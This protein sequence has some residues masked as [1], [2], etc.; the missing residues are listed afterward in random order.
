MKKKP[1]KRKRKIAVRR[2]IDDLEGMEIEEVSETEFSKNKRKLLKYIT[3]RIQNFER[4][5]YPNL[6]VLTSL[7]YIRKTIFQLSKEGQLFEFAT[8]LSSLKKEIQN[9]ETI[10]SSVI[11][12]ISK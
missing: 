9:L 1:L 6:F 8:K 3:D 2:N 5:K 10:V 12:K 7:E 11:L 4:Q